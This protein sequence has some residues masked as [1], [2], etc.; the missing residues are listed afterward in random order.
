MILLPTLFFVS[1][2]LVF[3]PSLPCLGS[4]ETH[5]KRLKLFLFPSSFS[6]ASLSRSV[7]VHLS[8]CCFLFCVFPSLPLHHLRVY[9]FMATPAANAWRLADV[10]SSRD[11]PTCVHVCVWSGGSRP[12]ACTWG[13]AVTALSLSMPRE[14]R[15]ERPLCERVGERRVYVH[16]RCG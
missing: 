3:L 10:Q 6:C 11:A 15:K 12:A 14:R 13:G 2:S 4:R 5:M 1:L 7:H 8:S 9:L 16:S